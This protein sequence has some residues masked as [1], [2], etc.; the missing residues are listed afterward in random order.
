MQEIGR[1]EGEEGLMR[2]LG[3][4]AAGELLEKAGLLGTR[5]P[6]RLVLYQNSATAGSHAGFY[7]GVTTRTS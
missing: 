7:F 1:R 4:A 5:P 3:A 2:G 6:T